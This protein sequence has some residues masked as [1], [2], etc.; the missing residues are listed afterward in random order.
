MCLSSLLTLSP[1]SIHNELFFCQFR[2][3]SLLRRSLQERKERE[4]MKTLSLFSLPYLLTRSP[5]FLRR[6]IQNVHTSSTSH[7]D[8]IWSREE[9]VPEE[10]L[11]ENHC[12]PDHSDPLQTGKEGEDSLDDAQVLWNSQIHV[13]R[14]RKAHRKYTLILHSPVRHSQS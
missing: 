1:F 7:L 11:Q 9:T 2:R 8:T 12:T 10:V 4:E 13:E 5:L 6:L 14:A 3:L